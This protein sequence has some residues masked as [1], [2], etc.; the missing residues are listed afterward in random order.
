M[1]YRFPMREFT[2][3]SQLSTD[4]I[5]DLQL[6][7]LENLLVLD[8]VCRENNIRYF[9][10]GGTCIGALREKGFVPWD[11]DVDVWI[12]RPDYERLH[13]I[14]DEACPDPHF[15]LCRNSETE[16]YHINCSFVKN[17]QGT[18]INRHSRNEDIN[19][20]IPIDIMAMDAVPKNPFLRFEQTI[21]AILES[22]YISQRL[23]D[24]QGKVIRALT[25]IPLA[26]VRSRH[27]R[28]RIW[29]W[30]ERRMTRWNWDECDT[31]KELT[32]GFKMKFKSMPKEWF[33]TVKPAMFE[34]HE[35]F[36]AAGAEHYMEMLFGDFMQLP[37]ESDRCAKHDIVYVNLDEG[38]ENF[39]GVWYCTDEEE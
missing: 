20:G 10:G 39:K 16:C 24:H 31:A 38:Y 3:I 5:R 14:W 19:H 18:F 33:D 17:D 23:P 32:T 28:Y 9:L 11:D 27:R 12:P 4:D 7:E 26:L 22:I 15:H 21:L 8:Q 25:H 6:K 30:C 13:E 2:D 36:I 35:V 29:K 1:W 37:P 34:G